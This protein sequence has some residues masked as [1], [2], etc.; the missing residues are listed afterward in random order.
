MGQG[1]QSISDGRLDRPVDMPVISVLAAA[2]TSKSSSFWNG[3]APVL[4][5]AVLGIVGLAVVL[6]LAAFIG[7]GVSKLLGLDR[8]GWD[9]MLALVGLK[10]WS[11]R[12]RRQ[13]RKR[14]EAGR[15]GRSG[16]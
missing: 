6:L 10:N 12:R 8:G 15:S 4:A 9:D 13:R 3:I 2:A 16:R 5:Y 11:R 1:L 7:V 14:R